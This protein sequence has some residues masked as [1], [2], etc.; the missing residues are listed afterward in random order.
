MMLDPFRLFGRLMLA[1]VRIAGYL[2]AYGL[3]ALWYVAHSK[4]EHVGDAIG[5]FGHAVTDAL[6]DVF[7]D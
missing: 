3:Q 7:R 5:E 1:F 2:F 6:A 4:R